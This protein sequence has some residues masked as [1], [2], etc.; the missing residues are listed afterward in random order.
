MRHAVCLM[1]ECDFLTKSSWVFAGGFSME[2]YMS[3]GGFSMEKYITGYPPKD[4]FLVQIL[5]NFYV[6]IARETRMFS[7]TLS[8][9]Y[10]GHGLHS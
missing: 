1:N 10:E 6:D 4:T 9:I 7:I 8:K 5:R 3:E 2:K